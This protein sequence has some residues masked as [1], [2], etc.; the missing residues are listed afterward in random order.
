MGKC[1]KVL[2]K[3]VSQSELDFK[4]VTLAAVL[5]REQPGGGDI[6]ESMDTS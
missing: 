5:R 6:G 4:S 1:F 2:N 3:E